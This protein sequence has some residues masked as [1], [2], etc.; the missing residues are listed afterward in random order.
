VSKQVIVY[1]SGQHEYHVLQG[2]RKAILDYAR[3]NGLPELKSDHNMEE[4]VPGAVL[5]EA[6]QLAGD[7]S[8]FI[9]VSLSSFGQAPS[10]QREN[11]L[12]LLGRGVDVH[13]VGLGRVDGYLHILKAAWASAADMER[14]MVQ[15]EKEHDEHEQELRERME[16][17]ENRLVSRLAETRG[18]A[19]VKEYFGA[20]GHSEPVTDETALHIR[21]LREAKGLSQEQL[22]QAAGTSKSM[23]QRCETIGKGADISKILSVLE[24]GQDGW[25]PE[26][27]VKWTEGS[28]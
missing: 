25:K 27:Q 10:Q 21:Q 9:V 24:H 5:K 13:V 18:V 17:F 2:Y 28:Q 14:R 7:G 20:N 8:T 1:I 19:V 11:I 16:R 22:A 4:V 6:M 3:A 12:G 26:P 23:V 15:M